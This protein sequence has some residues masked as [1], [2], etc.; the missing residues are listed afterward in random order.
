MGGIMLNAISQVFVGVPMRIAADISSSLYSGVQRFVAL[1]VLTNQRFN[2][3]LST[4]YDLKARRLTI[5]SLAES[6]NPS[7]KVPKI[8]AVAVKNSNG[9][10]LE[11]ILMVP[12]EKLVL[13]EGKPKV[14]DRLL[15]AYSGIGGCYEYWYTDGLKDL[16]EN[17]N[18]SILM[19]NYR[20]VGKSTGKVY[21]PNDLLEDGYAIAKYAYDEVALDKKKV[22]FYG[23]SMGGGVATHVVA[24]LEKE[25]FKPASVCIDRS[26]SGLMQTVHDMLPFGFLK[27]VCHK[28][29]MY[30]SWQI[31]SVNA[32]LQIAYTK[33]V[34][35][36]AEA[37]SI[38][39]IKSSLATA[40]EDKVEGKAPFKLIDLPSFEKTEW[41]RMH[42]E[43]FPYWV[44]PELETTFQGRLQLRFIEY[45]HYL[46][47]FFIG[48]RAHCVPFNRELF[49]L[50]VQA[51]EKVLL[52]AEMEL[53]SRKTV[54]LQITDA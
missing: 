6:D 15:V 17:Y 52:D 5:L 32:A 31:D 3:S 43:E 20:G 50:Q 35:V 33:L 23:T 11:G 2:Y 8:F 44:K 14:S 45:K 13:E 9:D 27:T 22:H 7:A 34:V 47:K 40:L 41:E 46:Q 12:K 36:R 19:V 21:V 24:R 29:M 1:T 48:L 53:A 49:P 18:T 26:Y 38:I 28:L 16:Y 54:P 4:I 10:T 51:Y 30:A 37:D 42:D 25:G 39:P